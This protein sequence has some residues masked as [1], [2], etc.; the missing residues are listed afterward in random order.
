MDLLNKEKITNIV[1][2]IFI[3]L[4]LTYL[5]N[6]NLNNPKQTKTETEN[7]A[8]LMEKQTVG[9]N[10]VLITNVNQVVFE[11]CVQEDGVNLIK[12]ADES[13]DW[14][15]KAITLQDMF[16]TKLDNSGVIGNFRVGYKPLQGI[17]LNDSTGKMLVKIGDNISAGPTTAT[18]IKDNAIQFGGINNNREINSAQISAAL[19]EANTLCI[20]GMSNSDKGN[21]KITMWAE[22][23]FKVWGPTYLN[24]TTKIHGD[25]NFSPSTTIRGDTR[26]HIYSKELLYLLPK[27]GTI[28]GKE[29]GGNGYLQVQGNMRCNQNINLGA[30]GRIKGDTRLNITANHDLLLYPKTGTLISKYNGSNGNLTVEGNLTCPGPISFLPRGCIIMYNGASA[31]GGWAICDGG[32]GTPDLRGRFVLGSGK[33][34]DNNPNNYKGDSDNKDAGYGEEDY[35]VGTK[36][37]C[38]KQTLTVAQ[39][40]SHDHSH[41]IVRAHD[42]GCGWSNAFDCGDWGGHASAVKIGATGGNGAHTNM[43]PYIVLL[44]IM[45]L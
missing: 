35:G 30:Q 21:R 34:K 17:E 44:Y 13:K 9:T 45:K 19:H 8:V 6:M 5:Y 26:L 32:N 42:D 23:G 36:G 4:S 2:C 41:N 33:A 7:F 31:P 24:G 14:S 43:P 39:M 1:I 16:N 38:Q 11:A 40:P 29:W 3:I 22:G 28:I 18:T 12:L 15:S 20:V 10:Q 25:L 27:S 37:G